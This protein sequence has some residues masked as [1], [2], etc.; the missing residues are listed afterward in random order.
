MRQL[1]F[2]LLMLLM[3]PVIVNAQTQ[4]FN[5]TMQNNTALNFE[6]GYYIIEVTEINAHFPKFVKVNL[7]TSGT[8][9]TYNIYDGENPYLSSPYDRI[10][11]RASSLTET[12]VYLTVQLPVEWSYPERYTIER[13]A[14]VP[15]IKVPNIVLTKSVD[16][17]DLNIDDIA[18]FKIKVENTGNATAYNIT[19]I[20]QLPNGFSKAQGSRFPP[21][22]NAELAAGATQELYYALKAVDSGTFNIEPAVVN[23]GSRTN[24]SNSLT[25]TV[26]K[27]DQLKSNLTIII[28]LDKK[29]V[30]TGDIIKGVIKITNTGE[31]AA[32]SILV[33][34]TPPL[35]VEVI[36]GD[37]RQVYDSINPDE[38]KEYRVTLRATEA[39]NYSMLLRTIYNDNQ[40]GVSSYSE[41]ITV[42]KKERNYL[43]IV[44]PIIGIIAGLVS[45]A[46]KR[47]K[48]YSY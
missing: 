23:Y 39:G 43:Y 22:I 20:E 27:V 37:L 8:S 10:D 33:D 25:I 28:T 45:F 5:F 19:L 40:A 17:T 48:E 26:A 34:G 13:S 32:K 14:Q 41:P 36:E 6:G 9:K 42:I 31:A 24:R 30:N 16:K 44:I 38:T 7:T 12:S 4:T 1:C 3:Y 21:V 15:S 29:D 2:L 11:I 47:H 18:E 46:I 35:G